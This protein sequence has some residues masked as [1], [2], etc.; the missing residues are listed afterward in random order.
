ME[1]VKYC[2]FFCNNEKIKIL[3]L[4]VFEKVKKCFDICV[5]CHTIVKYG[6]SGSGL[7]I[8]LDGSD[9]DLLCVLLYCVNRL[10]LFEEFEKIM[11]ALKVEHLR[12]KSNFLRNTNGHRLATIR[13]PYAGPT[14]SLK[15]ANGRRS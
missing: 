2:E 11:Q 6:S 3:K 7:E 12:F 5:N 15:S 14:T 4:E 8:D 10:I 13:L 1:I 9:M